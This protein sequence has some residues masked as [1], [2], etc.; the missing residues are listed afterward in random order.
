M[1]VSIVAAGLLTGLGLIVVI[2]AQNAYVLRVGL[3]STRRVVAWTVAACIASDVALIS[4]GIAGMGTISHNAKWVLTVIRIVGVAFLVAYALLSLR[5]A[6]RSAEG[7]RVQQ[8]AGV[9]LGTSLATVAALTWLN[10]HV[11][12]DTVVLLG[13][14]GATFQSERWWFAAGAMIASA[15]WF[16]LLGF[17]ARLLRPLFARTWTWRILDIGIA[18][19]MLVLAWGLATEQL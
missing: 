6:I 18:A 9:S 3:T 2:G 4:A 10:P 8:G 5:R 11:Y 1:P 7:L 14:I 12:L 17:G 19:M 15:S 16:T 13:S